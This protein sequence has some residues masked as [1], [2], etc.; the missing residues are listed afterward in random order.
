MLRERTRVSMPGR[1]W[2]RRGERARS[3]HMRGVVYGVSVGSEADRE[4]FRD[5]S[6]AGAGRFPPGGEGEGHHPLGVGVRF[7]LS[8]NSS[9]EVVKAIFL[10]CVKACVEYRVKDFGV[11]NRDQDGAV[12]SR[13]GGPSCPPDK[14][15]LP[16][17]APT[18]GRRPGC[19]LFLQ[20]GR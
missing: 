5:G 6:R 7:E 11:R 13:V 17:P 9:G 10:S 15:L 8:E 3:G 20:P 14:A 1:G 2:G 18:L 16:R 19:G 4:V 12:E